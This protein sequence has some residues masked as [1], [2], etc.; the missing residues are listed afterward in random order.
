MSIYFGG[1]KKKE[2]N[3]VPISELRAHE[4]PEKSRVGELEVDMRK[5][6]ALLK[7]IVVDRGTKVILDGHCRCGALKRIGCSKVAVKFVDYNSG[8]IHV[9]RW[10]G[11]EM[12]K[13]EVI[14]AGL[15]ENLMMPKTS[16]HMV[17]KEGRRIHISEICEDAAIPLEELA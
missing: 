2:V 12:T 10:D 6:G 8:S 4:L 17:T 11:G 13:N 1:S 16:K 14:D 15:N 9:E 5:R 3:L 7:P